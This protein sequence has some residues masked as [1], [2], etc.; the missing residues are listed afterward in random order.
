MQVRNEEINFEWPPKELLDHL[1][2]DV[3]LK[4]LTFK[5]YSS[6]VSSVCCTLTDNKSSGVI[7]K[8]GVR[9]NMPQTIDFDPSKPIRSVS[10]ANQ[11][12]GSFAHR[13][14][15]MGKDGKEVYSY[16]PRNHQ[17]DVKERHLADNEELIGFYGVKD[18]LNYF[19]TFGFLVKV[20]LP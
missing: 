3:K 20:R 11:G 16:N 10:A 17:D 19:T 6:A 15:F 5:S 9:H 13:I 4:S 2:A 7:E 1:E 18:K 12:G 14:R 8:E